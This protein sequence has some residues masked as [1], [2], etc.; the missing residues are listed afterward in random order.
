MCGVFFFL[1]Y[2]TKIIFLVS[3]YVIWYITWYRL[4]RKKQPSYG[5][6]DGGEKLWLLENRDEKIK[7]NCPSSV[8]APERSPLSGDKNEVWMKPNIG[9][10]LIF[11]RD[12]SYGLWTNQC[13]QS[14][15]MC[16][17]WE[18]GGHSAGNYVPG[19]IYSIDITGG[20]L[21]RNNCNGHI[22]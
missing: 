10:T 5:Y 16:G 9:C 7:W 2:P 12:F 13:F 6:V 22:V 21:L 20:K 15:A 17:W 4:K 8:C 18:P 11:Y 19:T 14:K 3:Q 1:F